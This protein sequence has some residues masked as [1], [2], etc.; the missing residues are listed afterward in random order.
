[1][2]DDEASN[3][4]SKHFL[5]ACTNVGSLGNNSNLKEHNIKVRKKVTD[6]VSI[7]RHKYSTDNIALC[8]QECGHFDVT[9]RP[10]FDLPLACDRQVTFGA[11]DNGVRGVATYAL[12]GNCKALNHVDTINEICNKAI[13]LAKRFRVALS[14]IGS[15]MENKLADARNNNAGARIR[16]R[17]GNVH[18]ADTK[19]ER[20]IRGS[21]L[22]K[23][24]EASKLETA[25]MTYPK[26]QFSIA[27]RYAA[28]WKARIKRK[29]VKRARMESGKRKTRKKK[30]SADSAVRGSKRRRNNNLNG[31]S[32]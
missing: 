18:G 12:G 21:F 26:A 10:H 30:R 7:I 13:R 11:D 6:T 27:K 3:I 28:A 24:W 16:T 8:I 29:I 20:F 31:R 1:M 4:S 15:T 19:I 32:P 22:Y 25:K 2:V 14:N 9:L 5:I 17:S 23:L